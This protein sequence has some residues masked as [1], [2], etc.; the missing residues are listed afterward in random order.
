M[1]A[2]VVQHGSFA[3]EDIFATAARLREL[4]MDSLPIPENYYDLG[5]RGL[6]DACFLRGWR[7]S[8]S[9][10]TRTSGAHTI[11]CTRAHSRSDS[12]K[13]CGADPDGYG[14]RD[15]S[16]RLAAQSRFRNL[17]PGTDLPRC[18]ASDFPLTTDGVLSRH[19]EP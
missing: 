3:T 4:S 17:K 8:T 2:P 14:A 11:M 16:I 6:E 13:W 5:A 18:T 9:C 10:T 1:A 19:G 12:S 7:S 15:T